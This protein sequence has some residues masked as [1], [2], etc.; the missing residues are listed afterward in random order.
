MGIVGVLSVSQF[1]DVVF[2]V[3]SR[4]DHP[5]AGGGGTE[6]VGGDPPAAADSDYSDFTLLTHPCPSLLD[7]EHDK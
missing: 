3:W 6:G 4:G 1:E 2:W 7:A 5:G